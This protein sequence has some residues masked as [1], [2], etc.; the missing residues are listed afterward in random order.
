MNPLDDLPQLP[1]KEQYVIAIFVIGHCK[2][3]ILREESLSRGL[4][5]TAKQIAL[6]KTEDVQGFVEACMSEDYPEE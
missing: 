6:T 4:T 5:E 2:K 1:T 3:K